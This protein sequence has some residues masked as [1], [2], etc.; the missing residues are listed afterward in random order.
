MYSGKTLRALE[1]PSMVRHAMVPQWTQVWACPWTSNARLRH[2]GRSSLPLRIQQSPWGG[3]GGCGPQA[4]L[5]SFLLERLVLRELCFGYKER[6]GLKCQLVP[7]AWVQEQMGYPVCPWTAPAVPQRSSLPIP[8]PLATDC[9]S[10]QPPEEPDSFALAPCQRNSREDS[11]PVA[12]Y[13]P[14]WSDCPASSGNRQGH[15]HH[16]SALGPCAS[17]SLPG[18]PLHPQ[19]RP[20]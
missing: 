10:K 3:L 1:F 17:F 6:S 14:V 20:S 18:Q 5:L 4:T 8:A 2:P 13:L 16:A 12:W 15:S 9:L 19:P 11:G 7:T